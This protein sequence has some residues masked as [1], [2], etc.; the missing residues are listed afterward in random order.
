MKR[1]L[2]AVVG[3]SL[4]GSALAETD[5]D[6]V[7]VSVAR[8]LE[9]AHYSR[10]KLDDAVSQRVFDQY[11]KDLDPNRLFFTQG[12]VD[13]LRAKYG[14]TLDDSILAGDLEPARQIFALYKER[15]VARVASN[16]A[17][18]DQKFTFTSKDVVALDRK[19]APWP[20]N[21]AEADELW[22]KRVEAELLQETL[23]KHAADTPAKTVKRRQDQ[24]LRN[25]NE[26]DDE[27]VVSGFLDALARTYDPHSQYM[28]P[29]ELANFDIE[30]KKS[31]DG[32]GAVLQSED[33]YAK[34]KE[35]VPGG[36]A[37]MDG[38]L[39]VNDR[40]SA[41]AQ[42]DGPFEDVVDMKLDKVVQKIRG[43]RGTVVRLQVIPANAA[44]PSKRAIVAIKRD[45][46]QLNE[47]K[48]SAEILDLTRPNGRPLRLG[49]IEL[50]SFYADLNRSG[51]A[52][53]VSTTKD[54]SILLERLKKEGIQG[55]VIDL[56]RDG[57]GS[58]EEAINLTGLFIPKG[59][60]VQAKDSNGKVSVSYDRNPKVAY[61]GPVVVLTN[62]LSAS[63]SE[64]F[65]AALQDYGR[66]VIVG[67]ERSFGK[68]TVQTMLD[69][70]RFMPFFSLGAS[71]AGALKLTINKFYRVLGGST[72]LEGVK[73]DIVLPSITDSPEIG[74]SAL[75]NPLPY[76]EVAPERIDR[77]GNLNPVIEQ[78]R[79]LSSA[80]VQSE[81]E[82]RYITDDL[83]RIE[84][85]YKENVVSLNLAERKRE[86]D[87][88]TARREERK[89]LRASRGLPFEVVAYE[90]TL[91]NAGKPELEKVAF[92]RKKKGS[93]MEESD[94]ETDAETKADADAKGKEGSKDAD[95]T[96]VVP[97]AIRNEALHIIADN[98]DIL[99][100]GKTA[101]AVAP[102]SAK[103]TP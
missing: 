24:L 70:G 97:D 28:S 101:S 81:P 6:K 33:G 53:A 8:L 40:I 7:A 32:V 103:V 99:K 55:L 86:L 58:L 20:K 69:I 91:E 26:M 10:Q 51:E 50:P 17:L 57:G 14:N 18:A 29:S 75:P 12:D 62:R 84:K 27:S 92:D 94:E 61:D 2:A 41:V 35:V 22:K 78:L 102:G 48:A 96:A 42:G 90:V 21:E 44:D 38:R 45:E 39:K 83:N 98:V 54:V 95:K 52:D 1:I 74:E 11:L 67:D 5:L 46:V 36:P 4:V 72:Q 76:D 34:V 3:L 88:D 31:L 19:D 23:N 9:Q 89:K 68:G 16:K 85:R 47:Q 43:P 49:W 15:V 71:D 60:V 13:Q 77:L 82:F 100:A 37:D 63:A 65:A 66:A 80:R 25:L 79:A 30:M 93:V 64:I 59:P 56:R 87:E 73:S